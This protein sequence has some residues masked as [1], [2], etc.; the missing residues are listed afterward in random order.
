MRARL[1]TSTVL[2]AVGLSGCAVFKDHVVA[3]AAAA[4]PAPVVA[5][6]PA[7]AAPP[8]LTRVVA[9][10]PIPNPPSRRAGR[11]IA[12]GPSLPDSADP[13]ERVAHANA[14]ARVQPTRAAYSKAEQVYQ[15]E[16]GALFQ[17]YAAPGRITDIAL[18]EGEQLSGTG[19][20]A[21]G[22][23]TRWVIGNTESGSGA[24]QRV[25]ILVKPTR[26]KLVTNLIV[27]TDRRTYHIELRATPATYMAS[28]VWRYPA[29]ERAVAQVQAAAFPQATSKLE[30]LNFNYQISGDHPAWR[31]VRV[32][33]DGRQTVIEF[34]AN[35][36]QSEMPPLFVSGPD[37]KA[38]DLV[39]Y[40]VSGQRIVID[41]LIERAELR[42]GD[43]RGAKRVRI[44]RT[45]RG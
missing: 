9:M 30:G 1:L 42:L 18:E 7:P 38:T 44:E 14:A 21:A 45:A 3:P 33:D 29:E 43:K 11:H 28:V 31:P 13:T 8:V 40:R 24:S 12:T 23:T 26:I 34:P 35:V 22:D 2:A 19:P 36:S 16:E 10:S 5:T 39:N 17:V 32:F 27:N 41:R 37:G 20:V 15:F 25:H 4:A 6:A